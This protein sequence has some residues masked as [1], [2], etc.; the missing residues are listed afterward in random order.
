MATTPEN[1][2]MILFTRGALPV[3]ALFYF[4]WN[5]RYHYFVVTST[6]YN[7]LIKINFYVVSLVIT[8]KKC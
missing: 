7:T 8:I 3:M 4:R 6:P 1:F 2:S 5:K